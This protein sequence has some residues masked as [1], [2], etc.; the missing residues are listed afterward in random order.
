M[1]AYHSELTATNLVAN[2]A[3]LPLNTRFR[4]PA[5]PYTEGDKD[6]IDETL[7]YFKANIFFQN[8]EIKSPSDRV[9]IYLTLYILDCLRTLQ[10]IG[11]KSEAKKVMHSLAIANFDLPGDPGF[12]RGLLG[13][14]SKPSDRKETDLM[15]AYLT[16]LRQET[17]SRLVDLVYGQEDRPSKW[18]MCFSPRKFMGQTLTPLGH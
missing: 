10:K 7:Y 5:L 15:R 1:P 9:L 11:N 18:W 3:L 2:L 16:Q 8:Y 14:F 17:G 4:G 6:I 13:Y 12:P